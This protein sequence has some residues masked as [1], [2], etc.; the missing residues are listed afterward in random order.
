MISVFLVT[1]EPI[2]LFAHQAITGLT[3]LFLLWAAVLF[4]SDPPWQ[5]ALSVVP[6]DG[7]RLGVV[8]RA[9][10]GRHGARR[11]LERRAHVGGFAVDGLVYWRTASLRGSTG[12][13]LL[14]FTFW[15]WGLH[16]LD[17]PLLRVSARRCC[18][19]CSWT[20]CS[21]SLRPSER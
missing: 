12:A 11:H 21:S 20:S 16:H 18:T 2:W 1:R 7:D 3:A 6:G 15:L 4:S 17:Y 10:D 5:R 19:A 14:A 8:Q 9:D 13:R